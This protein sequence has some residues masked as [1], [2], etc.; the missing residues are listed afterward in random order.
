MRRGGLRPVTHH[1]DRWS[2]TDGCHRSAKFIPS[3]HRHS[4]RKRERQ[5]PEASGTD[6]STVRR[7]HGRTQGFPQCLR[8][9]LF[10]GL[11]TVPEFPGYPVSRKYQM[12]CWIQQQLHPWIM[13]AANSH[14]THAS[15]VAIF[16]VVL[17][18][19]QRD[20]IPTDRITGPYPVLYGDRHRHPMITPRRKGLPG[21]WSIP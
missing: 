5:H 20:R 8:R 13:G 21:L 3:G 6:L 4:A 19:G 14:A 17:V 9:S 7:T 2:A 15:C 18:E 10:L 1:L 16:E 11:F 12:N